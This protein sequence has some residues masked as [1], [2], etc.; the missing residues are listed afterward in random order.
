[1]D[2]LNLKDNLSV[3]LVQNINNQEIIPGLTNEQLLPILIGII[4]IIIGLVLISWK[5]KHSGL[6]KTKTTNY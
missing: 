6:V 4:L 1:M 3:T 5:K 2:S